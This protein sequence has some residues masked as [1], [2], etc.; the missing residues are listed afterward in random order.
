MADFSVKNIIS[1]GGAHAMTALT[2]I[3]GL[4][5]IKPEDATALIAAV[6]QFNDAIVSAV[7]ALGKMWIIIGPLAIAGFAR[8]GVTN[9]TVQGLLSKLTTLATQGTDKEQTQKQAQI[10]ASVAELPK[11]DAIVAPD[12]AKEPITPPNVVASAKELP[13]A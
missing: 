4:G 1:N 9:P 2:V 6:H 3:A 10:A 11:V 8:L 5:W 7:G 12:L 13:K